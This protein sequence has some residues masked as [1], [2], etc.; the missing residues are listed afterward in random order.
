MDVITKEILPSLKLYEYYVVDVKAQ[1]EA[2]TAAW[3][4]STSLKASSSSDDLKSMSAKDLSE[5]FAAQCLSPDWNQLGARFH[6]QVDQSTAVPF[7]ASL[8]GASPGA[9]TADSATAELKRILDD[10]NVPRYEQY[11]QDLEA[12]VSNTK[13]RVKYTRIDEHGPKYGPITAK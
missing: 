3:R 5:K 4:K 2:F 10:I 11:N 1:S 8:T 13:N 12:I 7:I 6:A 9:D